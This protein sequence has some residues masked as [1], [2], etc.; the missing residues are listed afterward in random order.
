[1]TTWNSTRFGD[2][3][4]RVRAA[5]AALAT[6]AVLLLLQA[7]TVF[8]GIDGGPKRI[9]QDEF[10]AKAIQRFVD[11][12][13]VPDISDYEATVAP[14]FH[15]ALAGI[16]HATSDSLLNENL[17]L[18]RMLQGSFML[19]FFALI[20]YELALVAP[21]RWAVVV[22]IPLVVDPYL[23][24]NLAWVSPEGVGW[25]T[26]MLALLVVIECD[27]W[28]WTAAI[29]GVAVLAA[30][31][32][33]Q[34]NIWLAGLV[35]LGAWLGRNERPPQHRPTEWSPGRLVPRLSEFEPRRV[36]RAS[37]ALV[38]TLPAFLLIAYLA[39]IWGGLVPPAFQTGNTTSPIQHHAAGEHTGGNL[40]F[41]AIMFAVC[42]LVGACSLPLFAG[43][44]RALFNNRINGRWLVAAGAALGLAAALLV[45]TSYSKDHGRWGSLWNI[46]RIGP[47]VADRSFSIAALAAF[48]GAAMSVALLAVP[49]RARLILASTWLGYVLT[50]SFNAL[51][52]IRYVEPF[53]LFWFVLAVRAAWKYNPLEDPK[54]STLL[55]LAGPVAL[56]LALAGVTAFMLVRF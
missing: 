51:A 11:G 4:R 23:F 46:A 15:L 52:W 29:G 39:D 45:E 27:N 34:T 26:L 56:S 21:T 37:V 28:R 48:G 49:R 19:A 13:P 1:M 6:A 41:P 33:R 38:A 50:N 31:S 35:W 44:I 42:G 55:R 47:V 24:M 7:A 53:A 25:L 32:V 54:T 9:D 14:A 8:S 20:V 30:V 40:A 3:S 17:D 16:V 18:L 12:W 5:T 10:H 36:A 43:T 2:P 22:A